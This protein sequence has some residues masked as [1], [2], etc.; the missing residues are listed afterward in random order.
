VSVL[1]FKDPSTGTWVPV[2]FSGGGGGSTYTD[3]QVRDVVAA[4]VQA[5]TNITVTHNDAADTLTF[6][7]T[8]GSGGGITTEDA[9]DA[10]ATALIAGSNVTITYNDPANTIT[11]DV[12]GSTSAASGVFP[13]MY[14]TS[15]VESITGNA[16]RG[17]AFPFTGSTKLWVA[18]T[19]TDGL[20]VATGFGRIKVGWQVYI[21]D[22]SD[23]TKYAIFNVTANPTDKGS[24]WEFTVAL[25]SSAGSFTAGKVAMQSLS[26]A[27]SNT[28]FSTTSTAAGLAPGSNGVGASYFLNGAAAFSPGVT[29]V[30]GVTGMWSGTQAAYDALGTWSSTTV[31]VIQ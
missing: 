7:A 5:G 30:Q 27:Q 31:Y 29:N 2:G 22:F 14:Q 21:Q 23:S 8:G 10:V 17:N 18:E 6:A 3:E 28:L 19:T 4:F 13:F 24:Y 15:T 1:K 16:L 12:A 25:V 26:P 20:N 11:I 9:V